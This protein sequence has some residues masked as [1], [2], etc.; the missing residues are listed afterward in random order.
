LDLRS[1]GG[2]D[3]GEMTADDEIEPFA[4]VASIGG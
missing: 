1:R 3:V 4:G 2:G